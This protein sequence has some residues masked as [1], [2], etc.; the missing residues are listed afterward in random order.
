MTIPVYNDAA[1]RHPPTQKTTF[2]MSGAKDKTIVWIEGA[3]HGFG[4]SGPKVGG[5]QAAAARGSGGPRVDGQAVSEV[6]PA[7]EGGDVRSPTIAS[8]VPA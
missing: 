4:P 1:E 3:D 7:G 5:R 2:E 8:Q 6:S